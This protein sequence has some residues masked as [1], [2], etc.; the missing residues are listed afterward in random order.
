[1]TRLA[2]RNAQFVVILVLISILMGVQSFMSMP[3]SEDPQVAFPFYVVRAVYPGTSPEDMEK[4]VVDPLEEV[5]NELKDIKILRSSIRQG[6]AIV[7][8][9]ASFEVDFEEKYNEILR[10]VNAVRGD[11]PSNLAFFEVRHIK[12]SDQVNFYLYALTS[13]NVAYHHLQKMAEDFQDEIEGI[14]GMGDVDMSACPDREIRVSLDYERMASQNINLGQVAGVLQGNNVNIPGG[15]VKAGTKIFNIQSTKSYDSLEEI[16]N[17]IIATGDNRVVY[18]KDIAEVK[19][20]YE[21]ALVKATFN[22][23]KAVLISLKLKQGYN[24]LDVNQKLQEKEQAFRTNLPPNVSLNVGFEQPKVVESRIND[25][26]KN[27]LQGVLLVGIVIFLALGWRAAIIIITLIPLSIILAL[28]MLNGAGYGL[29]QISIASLV[30]ALGLLVD[31]GIVVIE[32]INRF[33]KEGFDKREA[34]LKGAQEVSLAIVAS[35]VTTLLSFFPL[36]QLGEGAGLFLASLPLTVIFTLVISLILSLTF[37]P[38]M[39]NWVMSN[40]ANEKPS[41]ADRFFGFFEE[42]VYRPVLQFS[43]K[44]GWLIVLLATSIFVFSVSLFPKIG[45]SFFP[46]ADKPLLLI[47]INTP[48]GS[49]LEH[50]QNAVNY[51]EAILD[52]MDYV[53]D[54]TASIGNGVSQIYYNRIPVRFQKNHAQIL[55]NLQYWNSKRFYETI[56]QLR[57]QFGEFAGA[58]I[59][60]EELKNGVPVDAPIEIRIIGETLEGIKEMAAKAENILR[61]TPSVINISNPIKR[62]QTQINV[63]LDKAKAGLLNV[64]ELDFDRT[65]R[66][67]L[68]GLVIDKVTT[69]DDE[70]Y[71]LVVRMPFD[72]APSI[73][74]FNKIYVT[75]RSGGQIPLNHIADINFTGGIAEFGHFKM[76]RFINLLGSLENLDNTIEKTLEVKDKLDKLDWPQ[77]VHY[78]LGGEYE[79]QQSTFGN[80]GVILMLAQIAIFAVL[81]LQFRSILQPL[82]VFAAIPLAI[83]GSF[84]ALYITGWP[85]SFFAFVGLISLIGIVV[86]NSIILVDYINQ[87]RREGMELSEALVL[88]SIRRFKPIVLTT[89]TTI[90]GLLPL[91][92]QA[93]NQW[94]PLCWTIIGGMIS[95][96]VLVLVVVPVLYG[97]LT[98]EEKAV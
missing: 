85:F 70:E 37:S 38:I 9:E 76:D 75:S 36:T 50:T 98:R 29:Q 71:N 58:E 59:T 52:T 40:K 25:F 81:V 95:S 88:G 82:I 53:K 80:L 44:R 79:E 21:D 14:D 41:L 77:D 97:W 12:P 32:N 51:V 55:A 61:T 16:K 91:T 7:S 63:S 1:M 18:L 62:E 96:S 6:I 67:S 87:L 28:A 72:D 27:L 49:N 31:N 65:V 92:L 78:E 43:L 11:L 33:I 24:I 34:S 35:T 74:D 94:S 89:I 2:I 93:T 17:S 26:F 47:D 20:D 15:E 19:Y 54:R 3:R 22:K 39:S 66:A 56:G 57:L 69:E 60:I 10:E 86:N 73:T 90:L 46:T 42:K 83:S 4:L 48:K 84:L 45:V 8:I 64:S 13:K 68:N 30:L 5:L 23:E